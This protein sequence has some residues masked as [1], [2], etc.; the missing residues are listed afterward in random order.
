M[1]PAVRRVLYVLLLVVVLVLWLLVGNF[2][3]TEA[4]Y[5]EF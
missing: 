2:D 1:T 5:V 3:A 4:P